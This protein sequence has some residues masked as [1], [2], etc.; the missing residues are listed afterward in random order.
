[1]LRAV[2]YDLKIFIIITTLCCDY[3]FT[4]MLLNAQCIII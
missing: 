3:F 1:M 4:F 2:Y